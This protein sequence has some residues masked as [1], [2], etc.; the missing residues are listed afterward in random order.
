[1]SQLRLIRKS[2][3]DGEKGDLDQEPT[4]DDLRDPEATRQAFDQRSSS[5]IREGLM[6]KR[7][8]EDKVLSIPKQL[9]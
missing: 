7:F 1:M 8:D 5:W 2:D 9:V 4:V 6:V 3:K